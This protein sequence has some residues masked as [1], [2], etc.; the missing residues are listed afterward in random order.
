MIPK[1]TKLQRIDTAYS[2]L[3]KKF[4]QRQP[5]Y[6]VALPDLSMQATYVHHMK[7]RGVNHLVVKTWL[8][9]C[10][11]CH[12]YIEEHPEEAIELGFSQKR[13]DV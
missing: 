4:V 5:M 12:T 2:Q 7:C 9:V 10:R 8:S 3:R 13:N 11:S 6:E 1:S